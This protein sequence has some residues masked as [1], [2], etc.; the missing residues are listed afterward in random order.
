MMTVRNG[1]KTIEYS[2]NSVLN[3]SVK[4]S[5]ICII[6]DG[7][8]DFTPKILDKLQKE[9]ESVL[10]VISFPDRGYDI[11]RI[12]HNWNEACGYVKNLNVNFDYL[13]II[14]DDIILPREYVEKLCLEMKKDSKLVIVSGSRG[15]ESSD[16]VSF[17]EGAGRIIDMKFF[18]TIGLRH[19]P[20]YGYE[21]WILFKALQLGYKIKKFANIKYEHKRTFG[22]KH[23]FV[24]YGVAM[25]CLGY[26]PIFVMARVLKNILSDK[27][28]ISKRAS[29]QM[30]F[31]YLNK[32][33]WSGDPYFKYF[34]P[35]L[36]HFVRTFQKNRLYSKLKIS[37]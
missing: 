34:E 5:L 9:N 32:K 28:G 16:D 4:P 25:R 33:K 36:R 26:H 37:H 22:I 3:Q 7:S 17:P 27:S 29:V 20:Y 19:P 11:R 6:D 24:E 8:V 31:D 14:A 30:I 23:N 18:S 15:L 12:V 2:I 35:D 21:P 13:V 10:H 1:E